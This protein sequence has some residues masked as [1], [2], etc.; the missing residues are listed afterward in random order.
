MGD[1]GFLLV[2]LQPEGL[3]EE[4]CQAG[5]DLL[6]F[7]L[8]TDKSKYVVVCVP[9]VFETPV[10]GVHRVHRG[11]RAH[12][13]FQVTGLR[14]V[15]LLSCAPQPA[16][17]PCVFRIGFPAGPPCILRDQFLLDKFVEL[18]QVDVTRIGDTTPPC[19]QP[20]SVSWY[21]QSSRYPAFSMFRM[22]LRN[23][24]YGFSPR[25]WPGGF[26]A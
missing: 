19:G 10:T 20:L 2:Q 13:F 9:N 12:L 8:R 7:G 25:V 4:F 16:L 18:V 5:L 26:H 21:S 24:L 23:R 6:G 3:P 1:Q 14:P 22:S 15:S 17:N 11:D